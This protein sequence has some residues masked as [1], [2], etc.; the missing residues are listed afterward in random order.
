MVRVQR[1]IVRQLT[2]SKTKYMASSRTDTAKSRTTDPVCG[3]QAT[4]GAMTTAW[5][6]TTYRFCRAACLTKFRAN[7]SAYA[8]ADKLQARMSPPA[9]SAEQPSQQTTYTCPM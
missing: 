6:G 8:G 1:F 9:G 5:Q 2:P 4:D 7:P 3:M